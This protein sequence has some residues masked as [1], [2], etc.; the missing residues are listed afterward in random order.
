MFATSSATSNRSTI[1]PKDLLPIG[2]DYQKQVFSKTTFPKDKDN[3]S[4]QPRWVETYD[5]IEYSENADAVFCFVCRQFGKTTSKDDVLMKTGFRSWKIALQKN[6]GLDKHN[7][8]SQHIAN[9]VSWK[10]KEARRK[11]STQVSRLLSS[12]II[13]KRQYYVISLI[14]V[15][16]Y[17]LQ[18]NYHFAV[19]GIQIRKTRVVYFQKFW[20]TQ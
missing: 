3:R 5:W 9:M 1:V 2:A 18:M 16:K 15:V 11:T 12:D 8:S 20:N 4:F 7:T 10:E 14:G 13:E 17:L 19:N 6:K